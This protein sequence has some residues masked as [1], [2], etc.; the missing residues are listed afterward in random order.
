MNIDDIKKVVK[1]NPRLECLYLCLASL[2]SEDL[3]KKIIAVK[4]DPYNLTVKKF[5]ELEPDRWVYYIDFD[6]AYK[7]NGFCSLYRL[8]LLHLAYADDLQMVPVVNWGK[9][10]LYYDDQ[11]IETG[12]AFEYYFD[13]VSDVDCKKVMSCRR[14]TISKG[15]DANAFGTTQGYTIPE[16]EVTIAALYSSKYVQLRQDIKNLFWGEMQ[17]IISGDK[18]LGVHVRA[19][20]YNKGYNRHPVAVTPEEYLKISRQAMKDYGFKKIFLATDDETVIQLFQHEFGEAL[21]FYK[22]TYRSKNGEAIHY[23]KHEINR[24]H[25]KFLLGL[26]I[27]KDFYTLGFCAGLIAGN[28]NVSM[29]AKIINHSNSEAY[30]YINIIDK[31]VNHNFKETRSLFGS[32][33]K[34]KR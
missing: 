17:E 11:I 29:C 9:N 10:T 32:M 12:N 34:N 13:P 28:S 16:E 31:G 14:V 24:E 18:T 33:I 7:F 3:C 15:A 5:G 4:R 19:T 1:K 23:G 20:D 6:E 25:H 2:K 8:V 30:Q 27:I 26:E 22:D 21:L